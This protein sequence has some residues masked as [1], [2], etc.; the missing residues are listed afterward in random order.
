[1]SCAGADHACLASIKR[2]VIEVTADEA[3]GEA[4]PTQRLDHEPGTVPASA[5]P[6]AEGLPWSQGAFTLSRLIGE[7]LVE[8]IEDPSQDVLGSIL[9]AGD[10][11]LAPRGDAGV[12][13]FGVGPNEG[14]KIGP[15]IGRILHGHFLRPGSSGNSSTPLVPKWIA[16]N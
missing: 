8:S 16:L 13:V 2:R 5:R 14:G 12:A 6:G 15:L 3:A 1:M 10:K 9:V 7:C 11:A 4:Q